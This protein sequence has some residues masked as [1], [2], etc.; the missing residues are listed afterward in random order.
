MSKVGL[1]DSRTW[2]GTSGS[3]LDITILT[4]SNPTQRIV[5]M[6]ANA[7]I[8]TI[9]GTFIL[10]LILVPLLPQ[11]LRGLLASKILCYPHQFRSE[12]N[13]FRLSRL[14]FEGFRYYKG[15]RLVGSSYH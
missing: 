12:L 6:N 1:S 2:G 13:L 7:I 5:V 11:M 14:V 8:V 10:F 4:T 15:K 3:G 9:P